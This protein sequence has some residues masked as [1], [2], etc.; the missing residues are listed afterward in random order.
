MQGAAQ[1]PASSRGAFAVPSS[2]GLFS[3]SSYA[4]QVVR[5]RCLRLYGSGLT[6]GSCAYRQFGSPHGFGAFLGLFSI[7][8]RLP[9]WSS[10]SKGTFDRQGCV[11]AQITKL[12]N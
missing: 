9:I 3:T 6:I 2:G 11:E 8:V 12:T 10:S 1:D 5:S 4:W 7:V